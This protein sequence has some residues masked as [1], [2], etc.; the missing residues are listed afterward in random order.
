M[1]V[2]WHEL[3]AAVLGVPAAMV[4]HFIGVGFLQKPM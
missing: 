2:H 3:A 1:V 4:Y